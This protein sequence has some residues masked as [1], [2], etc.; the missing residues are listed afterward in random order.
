MSKME[1][2]CVELDKVYPIAGSQSNGSEPKPEQNDPD[3]FGL[4][5]EILRNLGCQPEQIEDRVLSVLYQGVDFDV[6]LPFGSYVRIR[7]YGWDSIKADDQYLY[8]LV[9]AIN[10]TNYEMVPTV[11]LTIPESDGIRE[12]V[13]L[14]DIRITSASPDN[15]RYV[16]DILN[17]FFAV[18]EHLK[19]RYQEF[20]EANT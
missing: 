17:A 2:E 7:E 6:E 9:E 4:M 5:I 3:A 16:K 10:I 12:L 20:K 19:I 13:T 18:K 8:L 15:E 11:V 14:C 1:H